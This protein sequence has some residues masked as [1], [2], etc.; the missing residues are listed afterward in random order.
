MKIKKEHCW[1][2][3]EKFST[4]YTLKT[5]ERFHVYDSECTSEKDRSRIALDYLEN[6][7][8][9]NRKNIRFV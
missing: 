9:F 1:H 6:L 5:G 8:G 2:G 7:Y 3:N 4:R